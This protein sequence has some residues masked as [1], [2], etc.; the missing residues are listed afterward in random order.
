MPYITLSYLIL[1]YIDDFDWM[2]KVQ[3][4]SLLQYLAR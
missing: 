4:I 3:Y 1:F 2:K